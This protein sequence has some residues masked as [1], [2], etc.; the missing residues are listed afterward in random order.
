[1]PFKQDWAASIAATRLRFTKNKIVIHPRCTHLIATLI[2]A[3]FN[4]QRTDFARVEGIGHCDSLAALMYWNRSI[5]RVTNPFPLAMPGENQI[6][7]RKDTGKNAFAK[8]LA[9]KRKSAA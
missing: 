5:D 7:R 4:K 8:A 9:G 6:I 1:M 3:R 2:S